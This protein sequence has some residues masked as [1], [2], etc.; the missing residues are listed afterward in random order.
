MKF[1]RYTLIALAATLVSCTDIQKAITGQI[2]FEITGLAAGTNASVQLTGTGGFAKTINASQILSDLT[3]GTYN[4]TANP[5]A[6]GA[7]QFQASPASGTIAVVA[8]TSKKQVITFSKVLKGNLTVTISGLPSGV[9]ANVTVTGANG[10]SRNLTATNT[11]TGIAPGSYTIA[12]TAVTN[13]ADNYTSQVTPS[14]V[15]VVDEATATSTVTYTLN[16]SAGGSLAITINGILAGGVG[17]VLVTGP[18]SFSQIVTTTTTLNSLPPGTYNVLA[19]DFESNFIGYSANVNQ[20]V[21]ITSNNTSNAAVTYTVVPANFADFTGIVSGAVTTNQ[22]SEFSKYDYKGSTATVTSQ[23]VIAA[24]NSI[25]MD[26][27]LGAGDYAGAT[28]TVYGNA[29]K[30]PTNYSTFTKFR[31]ALAS[32]TRSQL[33]VK[34]TGSDTAIQNNGCY[35]VILVNVT[36]TLT[37]YDLNIADFAPR[38]YCTTPNLRTIAQTITDVVR[39]E[40]EDNNLPNTGTVSSTT[41]IGNIRV[42][43]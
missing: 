32:S 16:N 29:T 26:Y 8:G 6:V 17:N 21:I 28:V 19:T 34:V 31:I 40:I 13:G 9:N 7:V 22:G 5:V 2:E 27:T 25:T 15:T 37:N 36:P 20:N 41:T 33:Q 14:N 10:F 43:Q 4:F 1:L 35:P 30:T 18:N 24:T 23:P 3:L 39:L 38:S 42:L 12:A 11:I